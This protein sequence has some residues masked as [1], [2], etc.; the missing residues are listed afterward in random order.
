MKYRDIIIGF[1]DELNSYV[2]DS[3]LASIDVSLYLLVPKNLK[4]ASG[5]L[6]EVKKSDIETLEGNINLSDYR[7]FMTPERTSLLNLLRRVF[8]QSLSTYSQHLSHPSLW[9]L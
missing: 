7:I 1:G 6:R 9:C 5:V 3:F 2:I 4:V 8:I